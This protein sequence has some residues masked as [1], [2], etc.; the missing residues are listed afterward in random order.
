M[1][2]LWKAGK[3]RS[4]RLVRSQVWGYVA[5]LCEANVATELCGSERH[6]SYVA[7][8]LCG[9]ERHVSNPYRQQCAS[10]QRSQHVRPSEWGRL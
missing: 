2:K 6:V 1:L 9:S 8:E 5:A 3:W 7:T 4:V 10:R